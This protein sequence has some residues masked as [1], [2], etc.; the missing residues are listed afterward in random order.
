MQ[1][2]NTYP[3]RK[4]KC[5]HCGYQGVEQQFEVKNDSKNTRTPEFTSAHTVHNQL[6]LRKENTIIRN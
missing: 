4:L 5:I 6:Y 3:P 1:I 2:V